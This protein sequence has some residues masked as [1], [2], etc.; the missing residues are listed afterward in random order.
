MNVLRIPPQPVHPDGVTAVPLE[1]H[2]D[3]DLAGIPAGHDVEDAA[4]GRDDR[5]PSAAARQQAGQRLA[6]AVI[7]REASLA[8]HWVVCQLVL[9]HLKLLLQLRRAFALQALLQGRDLPLQGF[10]LMPVCPDLRLPCLVELLLVFIDHAGH[11]PHD[12]GL[13]LTR[14][15]DYHGVQAQ[16]LHIPR[17]AF[18][19]VFP[20]E[21]HRQ[22]P[23]ADDGRHVWG[24]LAVLGYGCHI[25]TEI[26][27]QALYREGREIAVLRLQWDQR[28][29]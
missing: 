11:V 22:H 5:E 13:P 29:K 1:P 26:C 2:V 28:L 4:L 12:T 20:L 14:R 25:V 8:D 15:G 7:R 24:R 23:Q 18:H 19:L 21:T 16:R 3:V 17:H 9:Q 10:T 27:R 6:G